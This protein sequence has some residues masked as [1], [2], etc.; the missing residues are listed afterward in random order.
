MRYLVFKPAMAFIVFGIVLLS[1]CAVGPDYKVPT[2]EIPQ[3][4][5]RSYTE[6]FSAQTIEVSWW[7]LFQDKPLNELV[8]QT[9]QHNLDLKAARANIT[10]ARALYLQTALNLAPIISSHANYIDQERSMGA[11]NNRS[12]V[13]RGIQL[14]NV[15]FDAQWE[16]DIFGRVRRS[17]EASNDQVEMQEATLRDLSVSLAAEVARNY[18][19]L[20]GLQ[21]Q[22]EVA[23]KNT[24]NQV[25]TLDITKIRL[26]GGRGTEQPFTSAVKRC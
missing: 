4:F 17:V 7:T 1:A 19:E 9:V 8:N 18:F 24:E 14:Y 26:A 15:G 10:Q 5:A 3:S 20:R 13:P 21:N 25:K 16:L 11:L 22:L 2:T 6:E 12:Y 23:K